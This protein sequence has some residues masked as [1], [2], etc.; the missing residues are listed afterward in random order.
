MRSG[1]TQSFGVQLKAFREAAG[2]TQEALATIA[3]LSVHAVSALERGERRRPHVETVRALSAALA[4]SGATRDALLS[5]ARAS[6]PV[7][8][9]EEL[10][11]SV[12]PLPLTGLLGRDKDLEVLQ[13]WLAEPGARLIT[14]IGPGGV[15]KSRLAL[16]LA[17]FVADH[18][19]LRVLFMSLATIWDPGLAACAIAEALGLADLT[20]ADLPK[21]ARAACD[22]QPTL[23]LL[24]NFEQVLSAAPVIAELL[25]TV[26]TLRLLVTSRAPLHVRGEREYSVGPLELDAAVEGMAPADLTRVP[27][28]RLFLERVRDV[29]PAF[30]LT[31]ANGPTIAAI[32]RRLDAMPLAL[33]L[34]APWMK[35]LPADDLLRRLENDVLLSAVSLRD[36]P[37]RQQTM[38]AT[39]AWSYQLL[40]PDCQW[41]FRRLSALPARFSI[42][43]AAA[44]LAG[45]D[46][47]T[48]GDDR[49]AAVAGLIDKSL[50]SHAETSAGG[51]SLYR[52]LETV[53]AYAMRELT[54]ARERDEAFEGLVRYCTAEASL[55]EAGLA[56]RAQVEWLNRVHDDLDSYRDALTWLIEHRRGAEASAIAWGLLLFWVIRSHAAEALS[57]YEEIL[58]LSVPPAA[59]SRALVG[60]A[61]MWLMKGEPARGRGMLTEGRALAHSVG[62]MYLV[63]HA[64]A[65]LGR[66]ENVTGNVS[67][68][69][70]HFV[71]AVETFET[72]GIYWGAGSAM[73]GW[74]N[75]ALATDDAACAQRLLDGATAM[76]RDAGPW[77]LTS[78]LCL[79][80][81][82]AVQRGNPGDAISLIRESLMRIQELQDKFAFVYAVVPLAQAAVLTGDDRWAARIL[83]VGDA[84][85]ERTG[86]TISGRL[87]RDRQQ[88]VAR[89]VRARLGPEWWDQA[90]AAGRESSIDTLLKDIDARLCHPAA[91]AAV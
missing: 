7:C 37:A 77:C 87:I 64:E 2:Y 4:L 80:A 14:L 57:W 89:E 81:V 72:L 55:A 43:A 46:G 70:D 16:E 75:L 23:L 50:L 62:D 11:A 10:T 32:C 84:V 1:T 47:V 31:A 44:V 83:G 78:V 90:Y 9:F 45:R 18:G 91:G 29:E 21:R 74:A 76:L 36:L 66:L 27:A 61:L 41:A 48:D 40:D 69:S 3:G 85:S 49:L 52:M 67:A 56:G 58:K 15:G 82:L 60:G 54:A 5:S 53:R 8:A 79:R 6:A 19:K 86:A 42:D 25:A 17:R 71:Q 73:T 35:V 59:R 22:G 51:R 12:L 65:L 30:S 34:A 26:P 28:I 24:D 39:L 38:N 20:A 63:A 88:T 33:E 68:A 13:E